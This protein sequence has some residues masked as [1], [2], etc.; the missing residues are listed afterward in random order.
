MAAYYVYKIS[1]T[2]ANL[3]KPMDLL[4][5]FEN[6]KEARNFARESRQDPANDPVDII[7][8]IFADNP[9][10]AEEKLSEFREKPIMKE[11]EK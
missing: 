1:P 10:D 7:K 11:W 8:V 4:D 2:V 3:V 9:L 6:Y 5:E